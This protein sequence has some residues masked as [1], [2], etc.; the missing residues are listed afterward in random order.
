MSTLCRLAAH[1]K[2]FS[3]CFCA[4]KDVY[5]T[6]LSDAYKCQDAWTSRLSSPILSKVEFS[7]FIVQ[8]YAKLEK[9]QSSS[10]DMDIIAN[11]MYEMHDSEVE[12]TES[13]I[14]KYRQSKDG[15]KLSQSIIHSIVRGYIDTQLTD[16]LLT[17]MKDKIKY[18]LHL[19]FI[20]ANILMDYFIK[21]EMFNEASQVA[22]D[23]ML[24]ED[25]SNKV[26]FLLS[27]YATTKLLHHPV[28]VQEEEVPETQE[29]E[30]EEEVW[31]AVKIIDFPYY[32]DH[33]SIQSE[34]FLHGKTLY[35]LGKLLGGVEGRSL[36]FIGLGMYEKFPRA[37]EMLQSWMSQTESDVIVKD[38][39][40]R[41]DELLQ[42]APTRDPDEPEKDFGLLRI[43]DEINK[44]KLTPSEKEQCITDWEGL[45][46][47][48]QS[49]NKL[50]SENLE[51]NI[52]KYVNN[53]IT[54]NEQED[55]ETL[56]SCI[57]SWET[58][59]QE[60]LDRQITAFKKK[61]KQEEIQEKIIAMQEKE[62]LFS[63]YQH[64]NEIKL[65]GLRAPTPYPE[66]PKKDEVDYDEMEEAKQKQTSFKR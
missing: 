24:Q 16:R 36:Q 61:Q 53:E 30:E 34:K 15:G 60:E 33:F 62:E 6:L 49:E 58:D 27:L 64:E 29:E 40:T 32:D 39:V 23:M 3:R 28:V 48:L 42:N 47:R 2:H 20:S 4:S 10:L 26:T 31:Q 65:A 57:E 37:L 17:M 59:R 66:P 21:K 14:E 8:V 25:F 18:G 7:D 55:I 50:S 13:V 9:E 41:F 63:Y 12:L 43:E 44:L 35:T 45:K 19:D 54:K 5:R 22:Y 1:V 56:K 51:E 38:M 52:T 46:E 11:K